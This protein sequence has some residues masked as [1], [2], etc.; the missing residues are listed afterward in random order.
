M[1]LVLTFLACMVLLLPPQALAEDLARLNNKLE[2]AE[3]LAAYSYRWDSKDSQAFA[4][5]FTEDA[6]MR[7]AVSGE[8]EMRFEISGRPAILDYAR[9]SHTN[10]LGDRQTRHH[11]SALIFLELTATTAL[12]EN[13]ALITHQ[14]QASG[15]PFIRSSGIYTIHWRKTDR[16]WQ[17]A[18]RL[19]VSDQF[20]AP[21]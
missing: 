15:A 11:M 21:L 18:N 14:T 5:L 1:K 17:I 6:V 3:V 16:G 4:E 20:I 10:R 13:M 8:S 19:L 9:N 12:T 2:I 7:R